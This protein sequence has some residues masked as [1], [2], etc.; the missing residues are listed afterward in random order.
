MVTQFH[1]SRLPKYDYKQ[2]RETFLSLSQEVWSASNLPTEATDTDLQSIADQQLN[3]NEQELVYCC[4][5]PLP[6]KLRKLRPHIRKS[7][8]LVTGV[9]NFPFKFMLP[10][11]LPPTG[12]SVPHASTD[13]GETTGSVLAAAP[14]THAPAIS[15]SDELVLLNMYRVRVKIQRKLDLLGEVEESA[16]VIV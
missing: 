9:Y 7:A 16:R 15:A 12:S 13:A 4:C 10:P 6:S 1:V 3:D 14:V 11:D 8:P 5:L 2:H